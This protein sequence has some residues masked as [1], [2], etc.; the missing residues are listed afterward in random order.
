MNLV[1]SSSIFASEVSFFGDKQYTR[2]KG[3]PV[4]IEENFTVP[5]N[6]TGPNFKISLLNGSPDGNNRVSSAEI[7]LNGEV[8]FAP[9]D[10]SQQVGMLE[11]T[12]ELKPG[13]SLSLILYSKP[14]SYLIINI[15]KFI[16]PPEATFTANPDTIQYQESSTLSWNVINA[17]SIQIDNN[18]G[19][20]PAVG[21][22]KV[23]P[24]VPITNFT[25]LAKNLGG[26][27]EKQIAVTVI[28][29]VP[30]VTLQAAPIYIKPGNSSTLTWT[31][32]A[33]YTASIEPNI[34]AVELN[35]ALPVTLADTTLFTISATGY[36]G[37]Q[38][39]QTTVYVD[40]IPPVI[41]IT[42]P[43]NDSYF[44]TAAIMVKGTV[45][46]SSP[47]TVKVN[48][49]E[50]QPQNNTFATS[51]N[52]NPG[53][54]TLHLEAMDAAA[55]P[56]QAAVT[57]TLDQT[58]PVIVISSPQAGTIFNEIP[59]T[60][61]GTVTDENLLKVLLNNQV[62]V[63]VD[64]TSHSFVVENV[65]L[66]EN[67]N[68]LVISAEDKAGNISSQ[69][70]TVIY[71]PDNEPPELSIDFPDNTFLNKTAVTVTGTVTDKSNILYVKVNGI[72]AVV[73]PQNNTY[74][75]QLELTE[76]ANGLTVEAEDEF[77]NRGTIDITVTVDTI[78][79]QVAVSS[80]QSNSFTNKDKITIHGGM[81]EANPRQVTLSG[82]SAGSIPGELTGGDF[83]FKDILLAEGENAFTV[84]CLDKAGNIGQSGITV[85]RDSQ[86]PQLTVSQPVNGA[87]LPVQSV[88]VKGTAS[89]INFQEIRVNNYICP[90]NNSQFSLPLNLAEGP[91]MIEIKATDLALNYKIEKLQ[92]TVDTRAPN[93]NITSPGANALLNANKVMVSGRVDDAHLPG[94]TVKVNNQTVPLSNNQFNVEIDLS[95]EGKT[96]ILVEAS[97][98][99]GNQTTK[100]IPVTRDTQAPTIVKVEPG[101][102]F[103]GVPLSYFVRVELSE[104]VVQNSLNSQSFYLQCKPGGENLEGT[105]SLTGNIFTFQPAIPFPSDAEIAVHI[106]D[107]L[108][109]AAGNI[110]SNPQVVTFFTRDQTAPPVPVLEPAPG[111]TS[112]KKVTVGGTSEPEARITIAG[113]L[114]QVRTQ[115]DAEGVF[116]SEVLLKENQLNQLCVY[117]RDGSGN[118]ST[119]ACLAV[120]QQG[121][122]LV[123]TDAQ[124]ESSENKIL[125]DFSRAIAA[126]TLT[127]NKT[128]YSSIPQVLEL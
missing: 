13:N 61:T 15:H 25:L 63:T 113:G 95:Q 86:P 76:G 20:V 29:P 1:N 27:T 101:D 39:A 40:G 81:V 120:Y 102:Q 115:C 37:T 124:L 91:N 26:E 93:L 78:A 44:N 64:P 19:N 85:V 58:A 123:V 23:S 128:V 72:N 32:T 9:K 18:I 117:A 35:G 38:N 30:T 125:V 45:Q 109:D 34:G 24:R 70:V 111:Q 88:L 87:L 28:F 59:I 55:N 6:Y 48:G 89:D 114:S 5:L 84:V 110:L 50:I 100:V 33:A 43:A 42:E 80:P 21:S 2:G 105:I 92:V 8:I 73:D 126:G 103:I 68:Q 51:V 106:T 49:T 66:V 98:A 127:A 4:T 52:L 31:S 62:P 112:L 56:A 17:D 107:K 36:G 96:E 71:I 46:D 90:L 54:N 82:G 41:S 14:D 79:P 119:P 22:I 7:K 53:Q 3:K 104:P 74:S 77:N 10:F 11:S 118:E 83:Y 65:N 108:K 12:V 116:S 97:D 121:G 122:E 57:C 47:L 69:G 16:N 94:I 60:V 99:A 67:E 75:A